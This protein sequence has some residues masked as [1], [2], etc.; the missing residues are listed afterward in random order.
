MYFINHFNEV[1]KSSVEVSPNLNNELSQLYFLF[2]MMRMIFCTVPLMIE[3]LSM[4]CLQWVRSKHLDYMTYLFC[5]YNYW[6]ILGN[7]LIHVVQI[8]FKTGYLSPI[9][10]KTF[11]TLIEK[12]NN[13]SKFIILNL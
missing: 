7:S 12:V 4:F 6:N 13:L 10:N 9:L 5:L 2:Q 8:F 11:I 1:F 3:K